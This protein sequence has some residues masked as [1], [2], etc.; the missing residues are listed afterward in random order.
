MKK[1]FIAIVIILLVILVLLIGFGVYIYVKIKPFLMDNL[2]SPSDETKVDSEVAGDK[3]PLLTGEQEAALERIG[4][5]PAKLPAEITPAMEECFN[6]Q[7]GAERVE[8]IK[9]GS[10]PTVIDFFK[11]KS[12]VN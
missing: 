11:A 6:Q 1:L 12:C 8:A 10:E 5:D 9:K 3:N 2:S 7:L 4:V